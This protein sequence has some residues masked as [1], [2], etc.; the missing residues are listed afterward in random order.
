MH[1]PSCSVARFLPPAVALAG[2]M[3]GTAAASG[4]VPAEDPAVEVVTLTPTPTGP[5]HPV[6]WNELGFSA[7]KL[8]LKAS[9]VVTVEEEPA[10][11]VRP[12]LRKVPEGGGLTPP[13]GPVAVVTLR[14]DLPFGRNE[15]ARAWAG[16]G[17][18]TA[19]QSEKLVSGSKNYWKLRR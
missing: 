14:T 10:A 12:E 15:V 18:G 17:C 2:L 3:L 8:F 5:L 1:P 7:R 13:G 11:S 9:T 19:L 16:A 6:A 4:P